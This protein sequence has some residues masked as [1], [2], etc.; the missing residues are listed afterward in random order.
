MSGAT[1]RDAT[2]FVNYPLYTYPKK[3]RKFQDYAEP[4]TE[5]LLL[6]GKAVLPV[7]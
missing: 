5:G 6:F 4:L 1:A 7:Q 2:K 3:P